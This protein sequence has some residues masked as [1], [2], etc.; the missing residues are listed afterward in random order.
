M[1]A[2]NH[3]EQIATESDIYSS[4]VIL[5]ALVSGLV[6]PEKVI[7]RMKKCQYLMRFR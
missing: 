6:E 3:K 1:I 7:L 2:I 4:S 5:E